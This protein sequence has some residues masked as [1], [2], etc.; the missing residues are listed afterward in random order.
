MISVLIPV[1]NTNALY[2][3]QCLESCLVQTIDDY[4]IIIIDNESNNLETL[5]MLE[6]AK[7]HEKIKVFVCP[8][9]DGKKNLSVALNYGL[10]KCSFNLIAR[11][12]SDDIMCHDRLEKQKKYLESNPDVDIVGGQIKIFPQ[13]TTTRHTEI[14][15][16]D[17]ALRSFWFL[18]HPTVMFK[19]DKIVSIGSY[20]DEPVLFAED[21]ELWIR[22]LRNNLKIRNIKDVVVLYRMHDKNLSKQTETNPNYFNI[23]RQQQEKLREVYDD[24]D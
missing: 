7:K 8:R 9:Q 3:K 22:S 16:K 14:I 1:Y 24:I 17:T 2:L 20:Q 23:M 18:N 19:K 4:E 15:T 6:E 11:M 10:E 5:N 21:Y 12:D 13:G